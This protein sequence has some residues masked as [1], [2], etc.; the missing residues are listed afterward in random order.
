[1]A[2]FG[3]SSV[4]SSISDPSSSG[5][6]QS[7]ETSRFTLVPSNPASS[8]CTISGHTHS[9]TLL[10]LSAVPAG[11][12]SSQQRRHRRKRNQHVGSSDLAGG[13]D[14]NVGKCFNEIA[15][16]PGMSKRL[17]PY[18]QIRIQGTFSHYEVL[19]SSTIANTFLGQVF[20][21]NDLPNYANLT[22]VFDQYM[23]E[24]IECWIVPNG[25]TSAPASAQGGMIYSSIDYDDGNTPTTLG[26]V[27]DHQTT[28]SSDARAGHY[29][30]WRPQY[31]VAAFSGTFTSYGAARGWLD[32]ASP[33]IEH[34]GLK[35][36]CTTNQVPTA[37]N[38]LCRY[39]IAFRSAG[40]N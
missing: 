2:P 14:V 31:A 3:S 15:S 38:V 13:S 30:K 35:V 19:L 33:G 27:S 4:P 37:Y 25:N 21:L 5:T 24:E 26:Q 29:H 20:Q 28:V 32:C 11:L 39:T 1:M 23:I 8:Q 9:L 40:I 34:Y 16:Y 22:S 18:N 10:G 7:T 17:S 6:R 36:A 12:I